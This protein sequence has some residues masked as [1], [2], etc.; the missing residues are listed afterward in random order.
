MNAFDQGSNAELPVPKNVRET[1]LARVKQLGEQPRRLLEAACL[2]GDGFQLEHLQSALA[3]NEWESLE[4]LE[5][6][7]DA[8]LLESSGDGYRFAHDLIRQALDIGFA[9]LGV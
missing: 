3:L 5:K 7:L 8:R 4:A 2:A 9:I 6:T 1:V